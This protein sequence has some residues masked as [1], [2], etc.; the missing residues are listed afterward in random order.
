MVFGV[1]Y[2]LGRASVPE[3][4]ALEWR[5]LLE[6]SSLGRLRMRVLYRDSQKN[7]RLGL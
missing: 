1:T 6:V 3:E 4:V 5:R 7:V 2:A